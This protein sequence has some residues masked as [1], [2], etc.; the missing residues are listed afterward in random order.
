MSEEPNNQNEISAQ[1][2]I[3]AQQERISS[4]NFELTMI[5]ARF[6]QVQEAN[7]KLA[8]ALEEAQRIKNE[9]DSESE[10]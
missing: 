6:I 5:T 3:S 2:V 10:D 9:E 1:S 7:S 4:L 8:A